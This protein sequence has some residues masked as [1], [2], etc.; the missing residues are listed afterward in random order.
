[1]NAIE[2]VAEIIKKYVVDELFVND[3][4]A[5]ERID[6]QSGV[7]MHVFESDGLAYVYVGQSGQ[8]P[9][10]IKQHQQCF[11]LQKTSTQHYYHGVHG[12]DRSTWYLVSK[13]EEMSQ[14]ERECV[15]SFVMVYTGAL[16][17]SCEKWVSSNYTPRTVLGI[18]CNR[19]LSIMT[20]MPVHGS[21][22]RTDH[23]TD[24]LELMATFCQ[25]E[26]RFHEYNGTRG[27]YLL[28]KDFHLPLIYDRTG[29]EALREGP[30]YATF[31]RRLGLL[32]VRQ[33][34]D[35]FYT[36]PRELTELI[37]SYGHLVPNEDERY[38]LGAKLPVYGAKGGG[39]HAPWALGVDRGI[40]T[41]GHGTGTIF[42]ELN[43]RGPRTATITLV[44]A[45]IKIELENRVHTMP[46]QL[47]N[48]K[49]QT[50]IISTYGLDKGCKTH[51]MLYHTERWR[52]ENWVRYTALLSADGYE[53]TLTQRFHAMK[54][55]SLDQTFS[56]PGMQVKI[57]ADERFAIKRVN[58]TKT[59]VC[60]A[61]VHNGKVSH[62]ETRVDGCPVRN[63]QADTTIGFARITSY[64]S[65][66]WWDKLHERASG[67]IEQ[68][69]RLFATEIRRV[70]AD[71]CRRL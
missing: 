50:H 55:N 21:G 61:I 63:I 13:R 18:G 3:L 65:Q 42:P 1:M 24:I 54:T 31:N 34:D 56:L 12:L 46:W 28:G 16:P 10:R 7:Y 4:D 58:M 26:I 51:D 22:Q 66:E 60:R 36:Y 11:R 19:I 53:S 59:I 49:M 23:T 52:Y 44:D 5:L 29:H 9:E 71:L 70:R 25:T 40:D 35:E 43:F 14:W 2:N 47:L 8:I 37:C 20:Y 69:M 48:E 45:G 6:V 64:T 38:L 32:T 62:I 39:V 15:E 33:E 41:V 67:K 27:V 30:A 57:P 17:L 68:R